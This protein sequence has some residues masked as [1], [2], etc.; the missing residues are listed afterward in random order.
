LKECWARLI[1]AVRTRF[2]QTAGA[3]KATR[4]SS[5]ARTRRLRPERV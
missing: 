2:N 1:L 5:A 3:A 4:S